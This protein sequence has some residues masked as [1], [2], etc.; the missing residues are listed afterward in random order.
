MS[1][2]VLTKD[3]TRI[4]ESIDKAMDKA[5]GIIKRKI[6]SYCNRRGYTFKNLYFCM[7]LDKEGNEVAPHSTDTEPLP[8]KLV[9]WYEDTFRSTF[10][11][12]IYE[13]GV[14]EGI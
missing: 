3:L 13:N 11:D 6:T 7:V 4:E 10:P 2:A 12:C 8:L 9:F 5:T 1:N 14:W